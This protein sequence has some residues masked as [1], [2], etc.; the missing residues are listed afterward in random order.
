MDCGGSGP[1]SASQTQRCEPMCR[2]G[3]NLGLNLLPYSVQGKEKKI[4]AAGEDP[5]LAGCS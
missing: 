3:A 2:A 1:G 4:F 5:K